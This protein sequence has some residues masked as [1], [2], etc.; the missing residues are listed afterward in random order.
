MVTVRHTERECAARGPVRWAAAS[1]P[2]TR[3]PRP[4][5]CTP[6][7]PLQSRSPG[8]PPASPLIPGIGPNEK[9]D[10]SSRDHAARTARTTGMK[11]PTPTLLVASALHANG[12]LRCRPRLV[13]RY[14]GCGSARRLVSSWMSTATLAS[15]SACTRPW[16]AQNSSSP[17]LAS[18]TRTYAWAPQRS[19]MSRAVSG[20]VGA[21]APVNVA[22]FASCLRLLRPVGPVELR[23]NALPL[24]A[25]H[26]P[27]SAFPTPGAVRHK[28]NGIR[29]LRMYFW[30]VTHGARAPPGRDPAA[31]RHRVSLPDIYPDSG[32]VKHSKRLTAWQAP[33]TRPEA[34]LCSSGPARGRFPEGD[35]PGR[36]R[37][38]HHR[39]RC[40]A[41]DRDRE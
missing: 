17:P 16:C 5:P 31:H 34:L 38:Y 6:A 12:R 15:A 41:A 30:A 7:R 14:C 22:S 27:A 25:T 35:R 21:M 29:A 32:Q 24:S 20:L 3:G 36:D 39:Y 10:I 28:R 23:F 1:S 4:Q 2:L 33:G 19:Q 9:R 11:K 37:L 13:A 40:P 8:P 26:T 18:S